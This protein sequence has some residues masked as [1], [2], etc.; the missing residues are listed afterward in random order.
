[1]CLR[2]LPQQ[3][4]NSRQTR[5][6]YPKCC[7]VLRV[8]TAARAHLNFEGVH[9]QELCSLAQVLGAISVLARFVQFLRD[10][11]HRGAVYA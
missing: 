10:R 3:A 11:E 6:P 4:L 9:F 2:A 5:L 8:A 1:M 7:H